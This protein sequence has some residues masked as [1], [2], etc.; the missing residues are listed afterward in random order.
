MRAIYLF[1]LLA[2]I[3]VGSWWIYH[4]DGAVRG[5]V[6]SYT[7]NSTSQFLALEPTYSVTQVMDSH[8][9]EIPSL[10]DDARL[11]PALKFYPYLLMDV[12]YSQNN[13]GRRDGV[14]LWSM[15]DGEMILDTT[16]WNVT[17]GFGSLLTANATD[18]DFR[19][20]KAVAARGNTISREQLRKALGVDSEVLDEWL[21]GARRNNLIIM[22]GNL[23]R[24]RVPD[25]KVDVQPFTQ[26]GQRLITKSYT[27]V[28]RHPTKF[29]K[30]QITDAAQSVFGPNVA[31][32]GTKEV[33]LP[34]YSISIANGDGSIQTTYW[35]ALNGQRYAPKG[36]ANIATP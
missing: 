35:N 34:V 16:S 14:V 4:N 6:S 27:H 20:V 12:T 13:K 7:E 32:R 26:I 2:F 31:I 15:D 3:G 23:V 29:T 19:V 25:A 33:F 28:Q 11:I 9:N 10:K 36:V 1:L 21:D 18:S 8:R 22:D 5:F 17:R 24:L 30:D